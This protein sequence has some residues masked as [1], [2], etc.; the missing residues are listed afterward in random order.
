[1]SEPSELAA[2]VEEAAKF[3]PRVIIEANSPG[4]EIECSVLGNDDPQASLPGEI[5]TDDEWYDFEAKYT[6]GRTRIEAPA[7]LDEE[8][9]AGPR[10]AHRV[11]A[12]AGCSAS[13]AATTFVEERLGSVPHP[14]TNQHDPLASPHFDYSKTG[15]PPTSRTRTSATASW[16]LSLERPSRI[17]NI[18]LSSLESVGLTNAIALPGQLRTRLL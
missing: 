9:T 5:L 7:D 3:D 10:L 14:L 8:T 16:N 17:G 12:M 2:A 11:V 13:P 4:R 15:K 18:H 6:E 1:V